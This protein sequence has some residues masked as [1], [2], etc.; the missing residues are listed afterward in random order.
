MAK[1]ALV[2]GGSRGLGRAICVRLAQ[3]G[4]NIIINYR[5]GV[6]EAHEVKSMVESLG[7]KADLLPYDV[8]DNQAATQAIASWF[9]AHKEDTIDVL[10]NNAGIRKDAL[11]P[12]MSQ[13]DWHAVLQITLDGFYN[14]TQAVLKKMMRKRYGRIINMASVS[15][16]MG[17]QG[18]VNYSAAK[19]GLI[20]AT[21]ALAKEVAIRGITVNAIAPGFIETDMTKGLDQAELEKTIPAGRFGKPE[22]VAAL[23]A[24]LASDDASYI[25][26]QVIPVNGGLYS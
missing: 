4:F 22:E 17:I 23:V 1:Y 25:T 20:G 21:K 9:D 26:G 13:D 15:G 16:M 11:L 14:T 8:A 3:N 18:Q 12:L 19:S 24:F 7:Q 6:N 10:V 5:S 2:T